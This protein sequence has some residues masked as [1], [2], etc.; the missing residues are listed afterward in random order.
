MEWSEVDI[1]NAVWRNPKA[2]TKEKRDDHVVYLNQYAMGILKRVQEQPLRGDKWVWVSPKLDTSGSGDILIG[3]S[4]SRAVLRMRAEGLLKVEFTPH[5]LR[6]TFSTRMAD[7]GVMPHVVEKCLDH[8][9][10]GVMA[11]Y[12]RSTYEPERRAAMALWGDKLN[13]LAPA[14]DSGPHLVQALERGSTRTRT[15]AFPKPATSR[16]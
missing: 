1:Q 4:L 6:R 11:V 8:L 16:T 15:P 7:M 13:E 12:N 5:D 9:M 3:H 10:E 2:K 14:P